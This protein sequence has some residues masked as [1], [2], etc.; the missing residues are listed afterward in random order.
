MKTYLYIGTVFIAMLLTDRA[1]ENQP[2]SLAKTALLLALTGL[3]VEPADLVYLKPLKEY[4]GIMDSRMSEITNM[5]TSQ[6]EGSRFLFIEQ[7]QVE[8]GWSWVLDYVFKGSDYT[9]RQITLGPQTYDGQENVDLTVNQYLDLL[10]QYDY[11]YTLYP[12]EV[13]IHKYWNPTTGAELLNQ[14]LY[15]IDYIDLNN[16]RV[17]LTLLDD[18]YY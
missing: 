3:F 17:E 8:Q 9:V 14:R 7:Y 18:Y 5:V 13:F 1:S 10:T 6:K 2:Y 15:H 4:T 12:D 16:Q 11:I